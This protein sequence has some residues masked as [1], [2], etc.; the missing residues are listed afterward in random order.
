MMRKGI[1]SQR[2]LP[3]QNSK[4]K[5][6]ARKIF[7]LA[8]HN[9][10][11]EAVSA[12]RAL[13]RVTKLITSASAPLQFEYTL[14]AALKKHSSLAFSDQAR[15]IYE[16][17]RSHG[18]AISGAFRDTA[19]GIEAAIHFP[20]LL[21]IAL[22]SGYDVFLQ[23]LI[24]AAFKAQPKL[25][26][27]VERNISLGELS[28]FSSIGEA[29]EYLIEREIDGILHEDHLSQMRA[30]NKLFNIKVDTDEPKSQAFLELCERRNLY[31]HNA[32]LVNARYLSKCSQLG[33]DTAGLAMN[34]HLDVTDDYL[35]EALLI[36]HELK[37]K[38][39]QYSWRKLVPN[40]RALADAE[41]ND[42]AFGLLQE[43]E[44][45]LAERILEYGI[46]HTGKTEEKTR[47]M[48]VVCARA[49]KSV[50]GARQ[51]SLRSTTILSP[52]RK[53][54]S[55][56]TSPAG[57][58][59]SVIGDRKNGDVLDVIKWREMRRG[60]VGRAWVGSGEPRQ[61]EARI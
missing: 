50:R 34:Q 12:L 57:S 3:R 23:K 45:L 38:L 17:H 7:F 13:H 42:A 51:F 25:R 58:P 47:L 4:K 37:I 33:I 28:E 19:S 14:R 6:K 53:L 40:E 29:S 2:T 41:L 59:E 15:D 5:K 49:L 52:R 18:R 35:R 32:G 60:V 54:R 1:P 44:Y 24:K 20:K 46:K 39:C 26:T 11:A 36:S 8:L 21:L 10:A 9:E 22:I 27:G 48:M 16:V 61:G 31:T 43:D 30:I 55:C 56:S